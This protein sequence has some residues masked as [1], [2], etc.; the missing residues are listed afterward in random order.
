MSVNGSWQEE[1]EWELNRMGENSRVRYVDVKCV[2]L[3]E[4]KRWNERTH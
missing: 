2:G 4:W 1:G 3:N